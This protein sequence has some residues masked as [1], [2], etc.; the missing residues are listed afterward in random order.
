MGLDK[1]F[2]KTNFITRP[3]KRVNESKKNLNLIKTKRKER[4]TFIVCSVIT[5]G[6]Q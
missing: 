3:I 5:L 1:V 2:K 4:L 6:H